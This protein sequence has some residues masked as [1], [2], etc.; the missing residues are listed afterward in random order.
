MWVHLSLIERNQPRITIQQH[1]LVQDVV[2]VDIG[3]SL[4]LLLHKPLLLGNSLAWRLASTEG[5]PRPP[6][7]AVPNWRPEGPEAN[8]LV[9]RSIILLHHLLVLLM[10]AT[11]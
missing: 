9:V 11:L 6:N 10:V 1:L 2:K 8:A 3:T 4:E 5:A 7:V